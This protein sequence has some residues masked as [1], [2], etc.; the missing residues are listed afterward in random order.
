MTEQG[1]GICTIWKLE[2]STLSYHIFVNYGCFFIK[3]GTLMSIYLLLIG[4]C[5]TCVY[6]NW[7]VRYGQK[8][9]VH[10]FFGTPCIASRTHGISPEL[11]L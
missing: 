11:I 3:F 8:C 6:T 7:V 2:V 5:C 9:G 4:S 10:T 1:A